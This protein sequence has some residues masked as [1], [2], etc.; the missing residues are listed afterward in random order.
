MTRRTRYLLV[1]VVLTGVTAWLVRPLSLATQVDAAI[2]RHDWAGATA[3]LDRLERYRPAESAHAVRRARI[4]R[5]QDRLADS[6]AA[7]DN[8]ARLGHD[9]EEI[10]RQRMLAVAQS[11][12]IGD[13]EPEIQQLLGAALDDGVAEECYEALVKGYVACHRID[14]ARQ[15]VAF[16][17]DWQPD[18]PRAHAAAGLVAEKLELHGEALVAYRRSLQ[19]GPDDV[20]VRG[21]VAAVEVHAGRLDAAAAEYARCLEQVPEDA[22]FL[23]GLADCRMRSGESAAAAALLHD[24]LAL[25]LTRDQTAAALASLASLAAEAGRT[26]DALTIY[27]DAVRLDERNITARFGLAATLRSLGHE[28]AAAAELAEARRLADLHR[29]L[30]ALTRKAVGEPDNA[31]LRIE[32]AAIL[33][34]LGLEDEG[35]RW[36]ETA[37]QVPPGPKHAP[38]NQPEDDGQHTG[39]SNG[40]G[41]ANDTNQRKEV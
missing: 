40:P 14:D 28:T 26:H 36:L 9:V 29:R 18:N 21:R 33:A 24:A 8:A 17:T 41:Q 1:A 5:R 3:A 20:A 15:C 30:T 27:R 22:G 32:I 37:R 4:L 19:S 13:I 6:I 7:L 23:L 12:R 2:R 11:G 34:D 25:D 31:T 35:S 39:A 16:W 10:R 38:L